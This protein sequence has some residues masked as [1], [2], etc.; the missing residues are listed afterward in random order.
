MYTR[1]IYTDI[2]EVEQ[3]RTRRIHFMNWRFLH[4]EC[5]LLDPDY[6]FIYGGLVN[7]NLIATAVVGRRE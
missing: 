1:L 4:V 7:D 3:R 6:R 5:K 2:N